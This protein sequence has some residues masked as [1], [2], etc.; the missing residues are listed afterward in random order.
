MSTTLAARGERP[1]SHQDRRWVRRVVALGVVTLLAGCAARVLPPPVVTT[2]RYP[3]FVFPRVPPGLGDT[4]LAA[5]IERAWLFLQA[6]DLPTARQEFSATV[7]RAASFYP[8]EAGL[9]YVELAARDFA[10]SVGRFDRVLARASAYVPAL[11]GRGEALMGAER[12]DEALE[13]FEAALAVDS[14]LASVA[15]RVDLLRFRGLQ[16]HVEVARAAAEGGRDADAQAAY[17]RALVAAP[18][19]AFLYRELALV[20][21][22]QGREL[23]ALEHGRRAAELDPTDA[24][25]L[26]LIGELHEAREEFDD[27]IDAYERAYGIEPSV[28]LEARIERTA[29]RTELSRLPAEYARIPTADRV[30]RAHLAALIGVRL[31]RLVENAGSE[32]ALLTDT[33]SHWAAPW[34][35]AVATAGLMEVYPNHTFEPDALVDRGGLAQVVSRTLGVIGER[36][37]ALAREWG[38]ARPTFADLRSGHPIYP[39]ASRAVA[40]GILR[41]L[42]DGTFQLTRR[43]RGAEVVE[44][45]DRLEALAGRVAGLPGARGADR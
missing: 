1:A 30:T 21:R 36:A 37:P 33:R 14:S 18:E 28:D 16:R 8:A 13:S 31:S 26:V 22:R 10:S 11:V 43:V 44:T 25:A 6:G 38:A 17:Q 27:A 15:R 42:E 5:E 24:A 45:V 41:A 32:A 40:A 4:A 2:P 35:M 23:E 9:G 20:E 39:A 19:S 3:D 12:E 34:I 7:A 29:A